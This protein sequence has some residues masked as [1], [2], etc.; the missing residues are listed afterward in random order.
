MDAKPKIAPRRKTAPAGIR[1]FIGV[2][3]CRAG[4]IAVHLMKDADPWSE[5]VRLDR[6]AAL[7]PASGSALVLIDMPIGLP[8]RSHPVRG[9][10]AAARRLLGA[11][12]SSVFSPPSRGALA[13]NDHPHASAVNLRE[14]GRGLS[15]QAWGI[16]PKIAALDKLLRRGRMRPA[17]LLMWE[18]HPELCLWAMNRGQ[19]MGHS[20][21]TAE[22]RR[23]RV[24]LLDRIQPGLRRWIEAQTPRLRAC[25]ASAD[26]LLDALA[27]AVTALRGYP[28]GYAVL[29]AEHEKDSQGLEMEMAYW[30]R[31]G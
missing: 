26:D 22:G 13:R 3:G 15:R 2:D 29:P 25:G 19:P 8:D 28:D 4:W 7:R 12:R 9:C 31:R 16:A 6:L 10:D 21:R 14:T 11:R 23:E 18:A 5:V 20:K 24:R 30:A 17:R 27:L 1:H